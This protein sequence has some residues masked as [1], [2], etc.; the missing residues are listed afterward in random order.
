MGFRNNKG[1]GVKRQRTLAIIEIYPKVRKF[2]NSISRNSVRTGRTYNYALSHFQTFLQ[3][4]YKNYDIE[5]V[6][7][8]LEEKEIDVYD[9]LDDF[10]GYLILRHDTSNGNTPLS[11]NT[12]RL[13]FDGVESYLED[14]DVEVSKRKLKRRVR[15]PKKY[16]GIKEPINAQDIR[17]ILLSCTHDTLKAFL[18]VLASSGMRSMEALT[19]RN[20]DVKFSTV[21]TTIHIRAE[22]SK[23]NQ[24]NYIYISNEA[25]KELKKFIDSKYS[26][27][28]EFKKYP[29]H[30]VFSKEIYNESIDPINIYRMLHGHFIKLLEKVEKDKRRDGQG[31]QR[32]KISFHLFRTYVFTKVSNTAGTSF[33]LWLLGKPKSEYWQSEESERRELYI[34]CE[35]YLTFLD[36]PTVDAVGKDFE[37]KLQERDKEIYQLKDGMEDLKRMYMKA[38]AGHVVM[39]SH[40]DSKGRTKRKIIK[41]KD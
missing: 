29:N 13:Y 18:L 11:P 40:L 10:V 20:C 16:K 36:Y 35:K 26:Q 7:I 2:L 25:S 28:D 22:I 1:T 8:A 21:P 23:T 19:L 15:L 14:N 30:L 33:A 3:S 5:T 4:E 32:R 41:N 34:K 39:E 6:L 17:D 9:L 37:S 12:I 38:M 24:E 27:V 31:M